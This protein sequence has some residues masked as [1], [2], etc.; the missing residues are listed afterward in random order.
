M[1]SINADFKKNRL[2]ITLGSLKVDEAK[3]AVDSIVEKSS[4]LR[5]GFSVLMDLTKYRPSSEIVTRRICLTQSFL[6][7]QGMGKMIRATRSVLA[8][9]EFDKAG[10]SEG[11][12]IQTVSTVVEADRILD[13]WVAEQKMPQAS[14]MKKLE[15]HVRKGNLSIRMTSSH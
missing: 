8:M 7:D 9:L 2:Y 13:W 6:N 10:R 5:F 1:Y 12:G 14:L 4:R 15:E 3:K 11:L